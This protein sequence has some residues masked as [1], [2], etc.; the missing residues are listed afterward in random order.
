MKQPARGPPLTRLGLA[1]GLSNKKAGEI[2]QIDTSNKSFCQLDRKHLHII[3]P[4]SNWL[5]SRKTKLH[6]TK[7]NKKQQCIN[8]MT[9]DHCCVTFT[10]F[11]HAISTWIKK[12]IMMIPFYEG[13][14]Q[15]KLTQYF[16]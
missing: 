11:R 12:A 7:G 6:S 1:W 4:V 14:N 3:L 9:M 8:S 15:E 10:Q 13:P 5:I 2:P 16:M